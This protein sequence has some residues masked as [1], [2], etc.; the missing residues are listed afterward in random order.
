ME[1][2]E[3]L[4]SDPWPQPPSRNEEAIN[5]IEG[6]MYIEDYIN[7][8]EHDWLLDQID[9]N[10]WLEDLKAACPALRF[11]IRLQSTEGQPRYAHWSFAKMA[12]STWSETL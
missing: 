9:K 8:N 7:E 2:L 10:P 3:L 1:Q 6:F 4:L 12:A 5:A 11:Q